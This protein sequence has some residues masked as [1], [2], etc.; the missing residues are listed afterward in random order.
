VHGASERFAQAVH[1]VFRGLFG[2]GGEPSYAEPVELVI[3]G[4][5]EAFALKRILSTS[6]SDDERSLE[7]LLSLVKVMAGALAERWP[8]PGRLGMPNFRAFS[9]KEEFP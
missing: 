5:L 3:V 6:E 9:K 8:R 2:H 4:L 1:E 7:P